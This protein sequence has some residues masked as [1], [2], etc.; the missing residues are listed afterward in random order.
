MRKILM[1]IMT[2]ALL[3][4]SFM[5]SADDKNANSQINLLKDSGKKLTRDIVEIPIVSFYYGMLSRI[6]TSTLM[7]L[8]EVSVI[9]TNYSTGESWE[10]DFDSSSRM[11]HEMPISGDPG[12]YEVIYVTENAD[13]YSGSFIIE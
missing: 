8:G 1:L 9:V 5:L 10:D 7:N 4:S 13:M 11:Y 12:F 3:L 2:F 6:Y